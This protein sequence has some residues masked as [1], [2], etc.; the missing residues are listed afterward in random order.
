MNNYT[1]RQLKI[2]SNISNN[3]NQKDLNNGI[4]IIKN[5]ILKNGNSWYNVDKNLIINIAKNKRK[6]VGQNVWNN[7]KSNFW[8]IIKNYKIY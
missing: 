5:M 7:V 2:I 6:I 4:N 8:K 3:D 1:K